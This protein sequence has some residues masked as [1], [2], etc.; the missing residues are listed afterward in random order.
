MTSNRAPGPAPRLRRSAGFTLLEVVFVA[1]FLALMAS[2]AAVAAPSWVFHARADGALTQVQ[3][4]FRRARERAIADRRNVEVRF[5]GPAQLQV[6][7]RDVTGNTEVGTTILE[8]ITLEGAVQ[9]GRLPGVPDLVGPDNLVP[10]TGT[11]GLNVGTATAQIF[12][13]E[14]T[15]VD[16][17]GDPLNIEVFLAGRTD[18]LTSRAVTVFGPT[19]L[20]R[21][22]TW[23]GR[24]WTQQ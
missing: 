9:F 4:T 1:A 12:T 3:T 15:F 6:V 14:G 19:A 7:R 5:T 11:N 10:G 20:I 8:T 18:P 16:Q 2:M 22:F 21:A 24:V 23:N 17:T 13:S